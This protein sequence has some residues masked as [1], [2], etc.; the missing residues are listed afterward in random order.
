[1]GRSK[2]WLNLFLICIGVVLGAMVADM[3]AQIPLLSWLSYGLSFGTE[4]PFV[5]DLNV[6]RLTFGINLHLTVSSV[7]FIA[8]SLVL[9]KLILRK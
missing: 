9:G 7:I 8:A 5:L 3:T 2:F 1:M 6:I 4:S